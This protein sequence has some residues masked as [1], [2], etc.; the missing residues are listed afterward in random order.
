M[1]AYVS[2]REGKQN[3][4]GFPVYPA[5]NSGEEVLPKLLLFSRIARVS[6]SEVPLANDYKNG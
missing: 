4:K 3:P 5:K 6:P 1:P 2:R